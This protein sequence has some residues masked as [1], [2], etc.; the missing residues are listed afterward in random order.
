MGGSGGVVPA[1]E[2]EAGPRHGAPPV[3]A[4]SSVCSSAPGSG[5]S[6]PNSSHGAIA[7]NGLTGSVPNIHAEVRGGQGG[8]H[9]RVS[10]GC[11]QGLCVCSVCVCVAV[12]GAWG[13]RREGLVVHTRVLGVHKGGGG[14]QIGCMGVTV[15]ARGA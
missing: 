13:L 6:S 2:T 4:V 5:P 8:R 9:A 12:L 1:G 10:W 11:A 14:V 7:E 15:C 3:P